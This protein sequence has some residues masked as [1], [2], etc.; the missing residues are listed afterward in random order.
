MR[1][2]LDMQFCLSRVI[3]PKILG[4][5]RALRIIGKLDLKGAN[6][7]KGRRFEGLRISSP[8]IDF[9]ASHDPEDFID[10]FHL[11]NITGS[12]Y[13]T[14]LCPKLLSTFSKMVNLPITAQGGIQSYRD[15]EI[16]LLNGASRVA[17]NTA[18]I[19][20]KVKINNL[21]S[22]FGSQAI[23]FAP[24]IRVI[25]SMVYLYGNAVESYAF[26]FPMPTFYH[27]SSLF[28]EGIYEFHI[29]LIDHDGVSSS[30][31]SNEQQLL[32]QLSS[33]R[34][35]LSVWLQNV[36][37][38]YLFSAGLGLSRIS[39]HHRTEVLFNHGCYSSIIDLQR[40]YH[41]VMGRYLEY[42]KTSNVGSLSSL[43]F[44][45]QL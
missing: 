30:W 21:V 42:F 18:I 20:N 12:L 23:I 37:C 28:A 8:L 32:K 16:L 9:L 6:I 33:C 5:M 35:I 31:N 22:E 7:I 13:E 38:N 34:R 11:N 15:I 26:L 40:L 14:N 43:F 3:L 44:L 36:A 24:A 45:L 27:I 41:K 29:R 2:H 17:I 4:L 39:S 25:D 1:D 19:Q 10:E